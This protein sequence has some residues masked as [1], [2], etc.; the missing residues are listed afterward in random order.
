MARRGHQVDDGWND[1]S[2][3][4]SPLLRLR[5]EGSAMSIIV[6]KLPDGSRRKAR[7]DRAGTAGV[8]AVVL[9]GSALAGQAAAAPF[10]LGPAS[11]VSGPSTLT[12]CTSGASADFAAAYDN[13]EV[14]PQVAVNPTDPD[15]IIAVAQQDRWPDGGAR[16][17]SSWIS[18]DGGSTWT[19]LTDVPWSAC[20]GGPQRFGR[21]TDPWVSYDKAGTAYFI[22][23]PIDLTTPTSAIAVT[24]L[25]RSTGSW[26]PPTTLT[27]GADE[28]FVTNDKVSVTGDPTR[29]GY[30]YATWLRTRYPNEGKQSPIADLHS[31][32]WRGTPMFSRT[33]DGGQTWSVPTAMRESNIYM[34]GNQIAVGPDGTLYD[35]AAVLFTGAGF[36]ANGIY[37]GVM[38]SRDAGRTWSAPTKIAPIGTTQLFVPDD[39]FP[40]RAGDYIPDIA[41]DPNSGAIYVVWADGRGTELNKTVMARSTDGGRHWSSPQVVSTGGAS[42]QAYNHA[43]DVT[44]NGTVVITYFDDRNNVLGDGVATT[45]V[46]LRHS[47][48]GGA[49]W[50]SEQHLLGPFDHYRA[51]IS[52]FAPGDPR[53]LFL[54]DYVGLETISG[55]NVISLVSTPA[56]DS[57]DVTAIRVNHP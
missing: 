29:P 49:T 40:I 33:T 54:G 26:R 1:N 35:A 8:V 41:I 7:R 3:G 30:A 28:R 15:E 36:N 39:G 42:A 34:Q 22:G 50:A 51:P 4:R 13:T 43:V 27:E 25:N 5:G 47:H 9:C 46:W 31:F 48:D 52:Y 56:T 2:G 18:R 24:T 6:S 12:A 20:Q 11:E 32:A 38:N 19:W 45:D 10:G 21:V 44:D 14:E 16:G 55:D 37:M 17:L 53:G 57:A 23:Q